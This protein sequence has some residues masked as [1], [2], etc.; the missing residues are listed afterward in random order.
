MS[1]ADQ[2]VFG[3]KSQKVYSVTNFFRD[4]EGREIKI[5]IYSSIIASRQAQNPFKN[6]VRSMF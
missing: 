5:N 6:T 2:Y 1:I 4:F 3:F